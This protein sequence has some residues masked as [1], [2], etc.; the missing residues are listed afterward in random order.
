MDLINVGLKEN[1]RDLCPKCY[2]PNNGENRAEVGSDNQ[3]ICYDN[4]CIKDNGKEVQFFVKD[5][6]EK[7]FPYDQIFPTRNLHEFYTKSYVK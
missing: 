4:Q 2:T 6:I 3:Y 1:S 5:D 7:K